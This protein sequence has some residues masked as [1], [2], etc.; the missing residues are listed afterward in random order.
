[1][2][3]RNSSAPVRR[4]CSQPETRTVCNEARLGARLPATEKARLVGVHSTQLS[5]HV[6][7]PDGRV[8]GFAVALPHQVV[9]NRRQHRFGHRRP[10]E[11]ALDLD[12]R[13]LP[14]CQS[15]R[16]EQCPQPIAAGKRA[17]DAFD[18]G[19]Q[20]QALA[21]QTKIVWHDGSPRVGPTREHPVRM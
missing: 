16:T 2:W 18:S 15:S 5:L 1:M 9:G 10:V 17:Y 20:A 7:L 11:W 6:Q 21:V 13:G 19:N 3:I 12:C 4:R 8:S 14:V